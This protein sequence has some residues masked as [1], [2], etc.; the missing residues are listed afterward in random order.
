MKGGDL[1]MAEGEK[2]PSTE[3][4]KTTDKGQSK[5][6]KVEELTE[7]QWE[8]AFKHERFKD[9]TAKAKELAKL[10]ADADKAEEEKLKEK[11]EFKGLAD[12]YQAENESLKKQI[13]NQSKRQAV[14]SQAV[15]QGVR[16]EALDDVVRLVDLESVQVDAEDKVT[17]ADIV[18]KELLASKTYLLADPDKKSIGVPNISD[19]GSK[20]PF[21]KWSEIE[22]KSKDNKWYTENKDEIEKAKREGRIN[23][24]E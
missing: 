19:G 5:S 1:K 13:I 23:Y 20:A 11:E 15:V 18:V 6:D 8:V 21:W 14:I 16:K 7:A 17:N 24:K 9:L 10:K 12:K 2:T 22:S 4:D 3:D